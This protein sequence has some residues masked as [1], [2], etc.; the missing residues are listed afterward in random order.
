MTGRLICC[1]F[2]LHAM[3]GGAG[4]A[5]SVVGAADVDGNT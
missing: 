5:Q 2:L 3:R 1:L 4:L